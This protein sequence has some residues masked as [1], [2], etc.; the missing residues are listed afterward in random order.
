[1]TRGIYTKWTIGG[2][3]FLVIFAGPCYLWYHYTAASYR[4]QVAEPDEIIHRSEKQRTASTANSTEQA[5]GASV[6]STTPTAEKLITKVAGA[7]TNTSTDETTKTVTAATQE[8][9]NAEEVRVSPHGFGPYPKLPKGWGPEPWAYPTPEHELLARVE[10]KLWHMGVKT[11]GS[12]MENGLVYPIIKGAVYVKW[13]KYIGPD[14]RPVRYISERLGDPDDDSMDRLESI[15]K[16]KK[17]DESFTEAD[18]P[19]DIKLILDEGG[20]IDP[21][22]FLDLPKIGE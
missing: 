18:V 8:T 2:L 14:G 7:E 21:Y 22:T 13:G 5:A 12:S 15:E 4:E 20:G 1:M 3:G 16:V 10:V 17:K 9:E 6:E 19:D 11:E